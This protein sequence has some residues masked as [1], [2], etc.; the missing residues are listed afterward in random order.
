MFMVIF[1]QRTNNMLLELLSNW[2]KRKTLRK[3]KMRK[4]EGPSEA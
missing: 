4:V 1:A 3:R 2:Y